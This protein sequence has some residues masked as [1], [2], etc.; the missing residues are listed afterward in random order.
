M[1]D[2]TIN[3]ALNIL[4]RCGIKTAASLKDR[5]TRGGFQISMRHLYTKLNIL[6]ED[7][8]IDERRK[9]NSGRR[10]VLSRTNKQNILVLLEQKPEV[11][12]SEIK[13]ILGLS[14]G[15]DAIR[16]FI[17]Q[18]GFKFLKIIER[19]ILSN[20]HKEARLQFA[21]NHLNDRWD[22][23]FFL[24]ESSFVLGAHRFACYQ[25]RGQRVQKD[26]FKHPQKVNLV[27]MISASGATRLILF[28]ENLTGPLF[29]E[30]LQTLKRDADLI[31]PT[32]RGYKIAMDR[33]PKHTATIVKEYIAQAKIEILEDWPACSPD[34]NP[35]E[36]LWGL[37]EKE[38]QKKFTKNLFTLKRNLRSIWVSLTRKEKLASLISSM[39]DRLKC[40]IKNN[41]SQ[42]NY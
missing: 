11:N 33:D 7:G 40:V 34:L 31:Y 13:S 20:K 23:T 26:R 9:G 3:D 8:Y 4:Y 32:K 1:K 16:N 24:D 15:T 10:S 37:M 6:E 28:Q 17:H 22:R 39:P 41:G 36:N 25:K 14:C 18:Q 12:A 38:L 2:Y 35:I 42:T 27:G 19:P 30:Y 21:I 5:L 29:K